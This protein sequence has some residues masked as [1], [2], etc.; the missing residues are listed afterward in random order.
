MDV[1]RYGLPPHVLPLMQRLPG[2][3]F[4]QDNVHSH[5]TRASQDCDHTVNTLP[6]PA[7][8]FDLSPIE[9]ISDY[10]GWR[11]GHLMSLNELE[12]MLQQI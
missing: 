2:A 1:Q 9:H 12:A 10:L 7:R 6:R 8:S 5:T 4:E 11:V 3:I